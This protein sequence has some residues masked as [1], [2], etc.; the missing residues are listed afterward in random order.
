MRNSQAKHVCVYGWGGA[1][2]GGCTKDLS[3]EK[4]IIWGGGQK[5]FHAVCTLCVCVC[6]CVRE[7]ERERERRNHSMQQTQNSLLK[8]S[9]LSFLPT[10]S[11]L[12]LSMPRGFCWHF[13]CH[14][15]FPLP[16][17]FFS[18][19]SFSDICRIK[20]YHFKRPFNAKAYRRRPWGFLPWG[21]AWEFA[22]STQCE[23]WANLEI[24]GSLHSRSV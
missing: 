18:L 1:R 3:Q 5:S 2:E 14:F 17:P 19:A 23:A 16:R 13:G 11:L 9:H 15:L 22:R 4:G 24:R 7:K 12:C 10:G 8:K 6:V 21:S 20:T